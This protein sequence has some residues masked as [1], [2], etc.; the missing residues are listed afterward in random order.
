MDIMT[1]IKRYDE[2]YDAYYDDENIDS[3]PYVY[4]T[5]DFKWWVIG[6]E[7]AHEDDD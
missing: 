7:D 6:Y 1:S 5:F 4:G 3:N 2:G